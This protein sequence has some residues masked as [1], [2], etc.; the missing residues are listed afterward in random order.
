[1][2]IIPHNKTTSSNNFFFA[3]PA[4]LDKTGVA[5]SIDS[6]ITF[7]NDSEKDGSTSRSIPL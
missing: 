2:V 7:G 6:A 1:M 4:L 5:Q 3:Q